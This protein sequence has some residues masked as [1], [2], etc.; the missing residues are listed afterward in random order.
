M[1]FSHTSVRVLSYAA[2]F[3]PELTQHKILL[4]NFIRKLL[5]LILFSASD[6]IKRKS[7]VRASTS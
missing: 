5:N 6:Y 7:Q 1:G 3:N 2:K 4:N